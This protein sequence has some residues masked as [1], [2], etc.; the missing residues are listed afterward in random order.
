M[1]LHVEIGVADHVGIGAGVQ[2]AQDQRMEPWKTERANLRE[3]GTFVRRYVLMYVR[4]F[5]IGYIHVLHPGDNL[6][7]YVTCVRT[8]VL[9]SSVFE[10]KHF[11]HKFRT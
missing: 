4:T 10:R 1:L 9:I 11:T 3:A 7:T 8:Y 2:Q 5:V 6:R